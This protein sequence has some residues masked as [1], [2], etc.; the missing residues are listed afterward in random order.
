MKPVKQRKEWKNMKY[1]FT[2]YNAQEK[3][4]AV[5]WETCF[6]HNFNIKQLIGIKENYCKVVFCVKKKGVNDAKIKTF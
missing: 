5:Q 6:F 2:K 3:Y 1:L 4:S